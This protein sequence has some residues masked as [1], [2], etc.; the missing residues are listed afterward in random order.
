MLS[1]FDYREVVADLV[2]KICNQ[3]MQLF[4]KRN[5]RIKPQLSKNNKLKEQWG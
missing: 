3:R 1:S 5:K 4:K 2:T